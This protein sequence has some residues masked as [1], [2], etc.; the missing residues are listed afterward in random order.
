MAKNL[1]LIS[2]SLIEI[3]RGMLKQDI[4]ADLK[5][6]EKIPLAGYLITYF[7]GKIIPF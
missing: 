3:K 1:D 6:L 5:L 7:P 2:M 4:L